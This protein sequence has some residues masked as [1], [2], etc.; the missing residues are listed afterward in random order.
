MLIC[1]IAL[2]AAGRRCSGDISDS[3]SPMGSSGVPKSDP[4]AA[5]LAAG[6]TPALQRNRRYLFAIHRESQ[7]YVTCNIIGVA[8]LYIKHPV[9]DSRASSIHRATVRY[10]FIH[11]SE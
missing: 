4:I 7:Q 5:C 10:N 2:R 1:S 6:G 9:D 11:R 3:W 8:G